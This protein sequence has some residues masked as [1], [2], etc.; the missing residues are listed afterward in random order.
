MLVSG[1]ENG[2]IGATV[3]ELP[4]A[5]GE[6][7]QTEI[8]GPVLSVTNT[9]T[10]DEAIAVVNASA[11]ETWPVSSHRAAGGR[12]FA[13]RHGSATSAS[14][15]ALSTD[16]ILPVLGIEGSFFGDLHAQGRDAIDFYMDKKVVVERWPREWSRR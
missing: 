12:N 14:T 7:R 13:T 6:L 11:F 15:S 3:V 16:G 5:T 8:F 10:L 9:A 4:N 2:F 1:Y